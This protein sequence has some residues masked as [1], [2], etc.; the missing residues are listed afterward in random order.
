MVCS[1]RT[2][3]MAAIY[4]L[5]LC[6]VILRGFVR[7]MEDDGKLLIGCIGMVYPEEPSPSNDG[8][9]VEVL[10]VGRN[11]LEQPEYKDDLTGQHLDSGLVAAAIGKELDYFDSRDVWRFVPIAEARGVTGKDPVSVRWVHVNKGD[12]DQPDVRS[13]L[14]ARQMRDAGDDAIFAPTPR[15]EALR[16]ILSFA[17]T[18][19]P[20]QKPHCR[21]PHS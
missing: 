3:R 14:V 5:N 1:G 10:A 9:G 11:V 15:L 8:G 19:L 4:Q 6:N 20:N 18:Q 13:R 16:T 7:Q 12:N 17:A 21:D 2:A